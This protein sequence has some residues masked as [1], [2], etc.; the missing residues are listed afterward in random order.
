MKTSNSLETIRIA[1]P[2][3]VNWD[4]LAGDD[5][6]R[7]CDHCSLQVYNIAGLTRREATELITRRQGRLCARIYR[8]ADGTIITRDCPVGLRAIRRR[9]ARIAAATFAVVVTLASSVF[10]QKPGSKDKNACRP[11]VIINKDVNQTQNGLSALNGTVSDANGAVIVGA[12]ITIKAPS[13]ATPLT[14]VS[15]AEGKFVIASLEPG[16]Y[17]IIVEANAF[18]KLQIDDVKLAANQTLK[19]DVTLM[20]K[21]SSMNMGVVAFDEPLIDLDPGTL[22]IN[23][24]MIQRLPIHED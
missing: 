14:A 3:A 22:I 18:N 15:D 20:V 24:K 7:F 16:L 19:L 9:T 13:I 23:Q 1:S 2:C 5:R 17:K 11:Q 10:G 8:R 6:V 21:S 4:S 12:N